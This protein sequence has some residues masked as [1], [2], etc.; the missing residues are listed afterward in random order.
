VSE[1]SWADV[2]TDEELPDGKP[3]RVTV[4]DVSVLLVRAGEDLFAI[5]NQCTHQGA[6][7]DKGS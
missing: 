7:L 2:A 3:V 4:G 5:G 1:E 6:A